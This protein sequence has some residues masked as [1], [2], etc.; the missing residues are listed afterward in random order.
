MK[1]N[2]ISPICSVDNVATVSVLCSSQK[3]KQSG[4][5]TYTIGGNAT[6]S[7]W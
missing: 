1:K 2:Y 5:Q 7:G 3:G 4:T 6:S